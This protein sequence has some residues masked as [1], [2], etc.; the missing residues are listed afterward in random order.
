VLGG[1]RVTFAWD[2]TPP[3]ALYSRTS[4]SIEFP[5]SVDLAA[6][7]ASLWWRIA[8]ICLHSHWPLFRPCVVRLPVRLPSGEAATWERLVAAAAR[9]LDA[10]RGQP[11]PGEV[12][13]VEGDRPLVDPPPPASGDR[14]A[15]A[16]SGGKDSLLQTALLCEFTERPLLVTVTSP[17]PPMKD[18]L[19]PY[20]RRMLATI[21]AARDVEL[22]EVRSDY[23]A[24]WDN[25]FARP[26]GY[27]ISINE[28]TDSFLYFACLLAVAA[29]R[30]VTHLFMASEVENQ[31][32]AWLGDEIVQSY[33]YMDSVATH[34]V[35][36]A[37]LQR[38]G[39]RY[40]SLMSPLR[41][42]QAQELLWRR[43]PD[44]APL[45]YSCWEVGAD[46]VA[47]G[48]CEKCALAALR[49]IDR[50]VP[51]ARVGIDTGR[52]LEWLGRLIPPPRRAAALPTRVSEA[53]RGE[54]F[55]RYVRSISPWRM[56]TTGMDGFGLRLAERVRAFRSHA[57]TRR[58]LTGE[59]VTPPAGIWPSFNRFV[60]P[61]LRDRVVAVYAAEF[62][63][64]P[65]FRH[66]P[67]A[68]RAE[69]LARWITEPLSARQPF[70]RRPQAL[71]PH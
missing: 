42:S 21:Q 63:P 49:L 2:I 23:R 29:A 12:R 53:E 40:S 45:Q 43:Y 38:F 39:I 54:D 48:A 35:L 71:L 1:G 67:V 59:P 51:P 36:E 11:L 65:G 37:I 7:P 44:I 60:D 34:R 25:H 9:T 27:P 70:A 33:F 62:R 58:R 22:V 66:L 56:A 5:D 4:F 15:T 41:S 46:E 14:C 10:Y 55:V 19:T 17:L 47:C 13:I 16:F 8:L 50:G 20:R 30:G 18:H 3:T 28:F 68:E 6:V 52:T 31:E 32:N 26:L 57:R 24:A 61:L 64:E 69:E